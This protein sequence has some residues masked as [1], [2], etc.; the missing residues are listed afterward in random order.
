MLPANAPLG[1][2]ASQEH[3]LAL[4]GRVPSRRRGCPP[5]ADGLAGAGSRLGRVRAL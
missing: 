3:G 2:M 4:A 1:P 5:R